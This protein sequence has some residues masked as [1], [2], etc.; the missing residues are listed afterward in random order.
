MPPLDALPIISFLKVDP[1]VCLRCRV[2]VI[3]AATD[4]Y[5]PSSAARSTTIEPAG[6]ISNSGAQVATSA[7]W[8][9][10]RIRAV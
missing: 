8:F 9:P 5:L 4:E 6:E 10:V 3:K 2:I 1:R 7:D